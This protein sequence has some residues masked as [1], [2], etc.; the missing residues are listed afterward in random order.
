MFHTS[1]VKTAKTDAHSRPSVECGNSATNPVTVILRKVSTGT[2][3]RM[4]TAGTITLAA[5]RDR[6]A[7]V[8]NTNVKSTAGTSPANIRSTERAA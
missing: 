4:S 2:D 1:A 6:A 7:Q 5:R 3:C 8:P